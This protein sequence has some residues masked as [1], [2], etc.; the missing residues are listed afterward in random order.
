MASDANLISRHDVNIDLS[1]LVG[2]KRYTHA[3]IY[4]YCLLCASGNSLHH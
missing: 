4:T 2:V 3:M 1:N